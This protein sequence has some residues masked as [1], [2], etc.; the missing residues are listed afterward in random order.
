[1]NK[2]FKQKNF[3]VA[4]PCFLSKFQHLSE[5]SSGHDDRVGQ[6]D[7][8]IPIR[9]SI[10]FCR[11][12]PAKHFPSVIQLLRKVRKPFVR[13]FR[14]DLIRRKK[15]KLFTLIFKKWTNPGLFFFIFVFSI[16]LTKN[17]QY[18]FLPMTGFKPWISGVRSDRSTNWATTTAPLIFRDTYLSMSTKNI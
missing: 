8:R 1:M 15:G 12:L 7:Q 13:N 17:I 6:V 18:K 9:I 5:S 2:L 3:T 11:Y 10:H 4:K 16:L 14:Q